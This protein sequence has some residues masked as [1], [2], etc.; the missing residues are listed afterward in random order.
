[1]IVWPETAVPFFFQDHR[2]LSARVVDVVHASGAALIF[3]SPAYQQAGNETRYFNR[4]YLLTPDDLRPQF[5]DKVHLVPFGEYVPLKRLLV[6]VNRLVPAAG[7]FEAGHVIH[8]LKFQNL[9]AGI[10]ICFE[11]IF[12]ELARAQTK[13]GAQILVNLTND[14]W[15]GRTSAPYQHLSMALFRAVETGR[16]LIRAANTGFSAFIDAHG[17]ITRKSRL[18]EE[19]VLEG[20][21]RIP[22]GTLTFYTRFGD[23]F[24]FLLMAI[25]IMGGMVL[26]RHAW[27]KKSS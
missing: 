21:I 16:P 1:L 10:L 18:F 13:A 20:R 11:A 23:L 6:F 4:A 26:L 7:D 24:A 2:A 19:A 27:R 17:R 5:Y 12:P 14:A 3:G 25:S 8:P 9:P 22:H 15:F